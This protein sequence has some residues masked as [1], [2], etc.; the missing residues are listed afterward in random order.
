M[1]P[2]FITIFIILISNTLFSQSYYRVQDKKINLNA[3]T[4][5]YII[6]TDKRFVEKCNSTLKAQLQKG[7]FES[8]Q[9]ISNNRFL[10]VGVKSQPR[11][12]S[13]TQIFTKTIKTK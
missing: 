3:D 10:I 12:Y 6:Q 4:T 1:K 11:N 7:E 13:Y 9:K 8:F 5:A 2:L